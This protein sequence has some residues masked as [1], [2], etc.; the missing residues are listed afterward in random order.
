MHAVRLVRSFVHVRR[1]LCIPRATLMEEGWAGVLVHAISR[2]F[3]YLLLC[4]RLLGR[5]RTGV[6]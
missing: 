5:R 4:V 2:E 6:A 3:F 1:F